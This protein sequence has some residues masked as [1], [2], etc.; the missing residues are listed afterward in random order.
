MLLVAELICAVLLVGRPQAPSGARRSRPRPPRSPRPPRRR[1]TADAAATAAPCTS[2]AWAG[3]RR[4]PLLAR[5]AAEMDDAVAG[6]H[7]V[8]GPRLAARHRHRGRRIRRRSSRAL[9]GGGSDI[10]A[11]TTAERI[12][13]APGAA[14]MSDAVAANCVAPR[15]F[16]LR[17]PRRRPPP[18]RRA[19][20]PRA[21]PTSSAARAAPRPR[22]RRTSCAR[23][24][25]DA[26]LDAAGPD[27]VARPTTAPGGSAG[28]SP[29]GTARQ[30][31]R[32]C[33]CGR[34]VQAIPTSPPRCARPSAPDLDE[35]LVRLAALAA[36]L[37]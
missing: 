6:R 16:S 20:S 21:S 22:G 26:D 35:V 4:Q 10:A 19:G 36:R 3:R 5:I 9:A 34:A 13:F 2:S 12:V 32:R 17:R 18:T 15:A 29:T 31:L 1:R 27:R 14:A 24:P 37:A 23:L 28:S 11:T 33:T 7:R 25:T 30:T 8:L